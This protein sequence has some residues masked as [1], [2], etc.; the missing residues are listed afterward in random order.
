VSST[1]KVSPSDPLARALHFRS[2]RGM[3]LAY[4]CFEVFLRALISPKKDGRRFLLSPFNLIVAAIARRTSPNFPFYPFN[5]EAGILFSGGRLQK[6]LPP[7]LFHPIR[8]GG[9]ILLFFDS[10]AQSFSLKK[11]ISHCL[12]GIRSFPFFMS[13]SPGYIRQSLAQSR[14]LCAFFF[15]LPLLR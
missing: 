7:S 11:L 6:C 4:S 1:L 2:L 10:S 15:F 12:F 3:R 9:D 8:V 5:P 13:V 14:L